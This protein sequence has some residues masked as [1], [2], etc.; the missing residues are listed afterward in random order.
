MGLVSS[1]TRW[2]P[3][4]KH[5]WY[6]LCWD[7]HRRWPRSCLMLTSSAYA[8]YQH[9]ADTTHVQRSC[10]ACRG[11]TSNS[12]EGP[13]DLVGFSEQWRLDLQWWNQDLKV[14]RASRASL[15]AILFSVEPLTILPL[16]FVGF[17]SMPSDPQI[18]DTDGPISH[19]HRVA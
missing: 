2:H 4:H 1:S 7:E 3:H 14:P 6:G 16:S 18:I 17:T 19:R 10:H 12:V 8:G 11:P 9:N 15:Y 13:M 5:S